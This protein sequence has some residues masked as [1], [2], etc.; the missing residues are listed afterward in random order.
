[1]ENNHSTLTPHAHTQNEISLEN[2]VSLAK[3]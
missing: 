1:M 3:M 2:A